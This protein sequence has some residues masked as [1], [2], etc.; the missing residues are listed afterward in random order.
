MAET[1]V[2]GS[3]GSRL[4]LWQS[5]YVADLLAMDG[6]V[7]QVRVFS[8]RGD[9]IQDRPL[10]EIGGKGLFTAEL[11]AALRTG[12]VDLAVHSLKDLPTDSPADLCVG[13]IPHRADPHDVVVSRDGATLDA[14]PHQA[15]VGTSSRRRAAQLKAYRPDLQIMA[16]RGNVETRVK[17]ARMPDGPYDAIVLAR[18]GLDRLDMLAFATQTLD[19]NV[20]LN[21]AGQGALGVQCRDDVISRERLSSLHDA[22]T[23]HCVTAERAFLAALGGGGSLPVAAHATLDAGQVFLRGRVCALDGSQVIDVHGQASLGVDPAD[24]SRELGKALAVQA[25]AQGA[26]AILSRLV[27]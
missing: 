25:L 21:A 4:A 3:R 12:E 16:I 18:A 27:P 23:A 11:E 10:P 24:D 22:P 2:I 13:A 15:V 20:M 9:Q 26:D 14:L 7:T 1:L 5:H 8:T 17:K 6:Y 19:F